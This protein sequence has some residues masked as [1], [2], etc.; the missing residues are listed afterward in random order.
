MAPEPTRQ[1]TARCDHLKSSYIPCGET[2]RDIL[3][4]GERKREAKSCHVSL[5]EILCLSSFWSFS[6]PD[7]SAL[8]RACD[9][10]RGLR[11]L[12]LKLELGPS[13]S[14]PQ[15]ED[16]SR[17]DLVLCSCTVRSLVSP[18]PPIL[19]RLKSTVR[20]AHDWFARE[21]RTELVHHLSTPHH[22][23]R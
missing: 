7:V 8:S 20:F 17:A 22:I 2:Q 23:R 19:L 5:Y 16:D 3:V 21:R 9:S 10:A 15:A 11:L 6:T 18:S 13:D 4:E 1:G 14:M 12:V